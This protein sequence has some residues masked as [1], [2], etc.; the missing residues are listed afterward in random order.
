MQD[1]RGKDQIE[2]LVRK[3]QWFVD[4]RRQQPRPP[5]QATL[6]DFKHAGTGV[7]PGHHSPALKQRCRMRPTAASR[8]EHGKP[9]DVANQGK[10]GRPL[11]IGIPGIDLVI[12][13]ISRRERIIIILGQVFPFPK[14]VRGCLCIGT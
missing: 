5:F 9:G 7:D 12:G 3:R 1:K 4:I 13:I 14:T 8:I 6:R 10:N 11:V 2:S